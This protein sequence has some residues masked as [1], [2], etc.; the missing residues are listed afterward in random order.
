MSTFT[1]QQVIKFTEAGD[2]REPVRPFEVTVLDVFDA[3][4]AVRVLSSAYMDY[5]HIAKFGDEWKLV[6]V[7]WQHR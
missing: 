4:N 3:I 7:L 5:L 1:R 6:T 2:R